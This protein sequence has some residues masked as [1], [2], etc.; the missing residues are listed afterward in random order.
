[1]ILIVGGSGVLGQRTARLLL[2]EGHPV[3]VMTRDPARA[4]EL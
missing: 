1:M 2:A 4:A 3:R